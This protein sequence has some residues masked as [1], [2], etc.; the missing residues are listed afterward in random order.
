[1]I[2]GIAF[3]L[4][5][6]FTKVAVPTVTKL[7]VDRGIVNP[8]PGELLRYTLVVLALG[9]V[10]AICAGMRRLSAF[11]VS[12]LTETAL[13]TR[14]FAHLQR[15]HF[16]F[17][18]GAQTGQLMATANTDLKS[19]EAFLTMV[20]ITIGNIVTMLSVSVIL[21]L[22]DV[23]LAACALAALPLLNF[24]ARRFSIT[25]FPQQAG[26]QEELAQLSGVV[27]ETMSG[28]RVVKGFG[29][30]RRQQHRF[31]EEVD[32]VY[33]RAL[34]AARI[35]AKFVPLL[36]VVPQIGLVAILWVGGHRVL[37]GR[38]SI[39]ELLAFNSYVLMLVWPLRSTGMLIAQA[40]R[41]AVAAT[42]V[43]KV[44]AT[45]P[46]I[47]DPPH[48]LA[49]PVRASL[50]TGGR[51]TVGAVRF[52]DV[53]FAY[54]AEGSSP[55]LDG[56]T[57]DIQPGEA[58]ALVGGTASGKTTV[59]RLLPRFYD[60]DAGRILLDGIDVRS[61]ALAELR[62]AV[63][64]VFEDTFLFTD[65][66]RANMAFANPAADPASVERAARLSGAY[67]FVQELPDGFETVLAERGQSLS[68]GQRQRI[69]IARA[70]LAGP[71]V[72]VLDD[73]TSAVDP[74]K[75][76]EIRAALAE[77]MRGRTTIVIA[78]RSATIA[79][80]DRVVFLDGGRVAAQGTHAE[81]LAANERYR[82]VLDHAED[83]SRVGSA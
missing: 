34:A 49:L 51:P 75:E 63:S 57:L 55:I 20:P 68:G 73:A 53:R 60:I 64:I 25:L 10:S 78:H 28:V 3:S 58:V 74:S 27:E 40:Q 46:E 32:D 13:R 1:M 48:P 56:F 19:V 37:D 47:V 59:A 22:T 42:R 33:D 26:L 15:L 66:V 67:E 39:G 43:A 4:L 81:L 44:L 9:V 24:I 29:A 80:A 82:E 83:E 5:W 77:V 2:S 36:D 54:G 70:I 38:L 52:E 65:T 41:A 12:Y 50:D 23:P 8:R 61:L 21:F 72:L 69:A 18:D 17:H 7:A 71:R 16:G 31:A 11:T 30:Q 6:T 35:R 62:R 79:L 76:R 14:L 45:E